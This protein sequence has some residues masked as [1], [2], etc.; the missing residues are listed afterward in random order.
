M[1]EAL[2]GPSNA[3][4]NLQK[5]TSVDRTLQQDRITSSRRLEQ[6][7]R[8]SSQ[9]TGALD[10]EFHAFQAPRIPNIPLQRAQLPLAHITR[11]ATP[12]LK[13][14]P[15]WASDFQK[16]NVSDP[17]TILPQ[18][19]QINYPLDTI[20]GGWHTE[21]MS[22]KNLPSQQMNIPQTMLQP[23]YQG[24]EPYVAGDTYA[25]GPQRMLPEQAIQGN[26][27]YDDAAFAQAFDQA[28]AEVQKNSENKGKEKAP[29]AFDMSFACTDPGDVMG[30]Y[31]FDAAQLGLTQEYTIPMTESEA[32]VLQTAYDEQLG[33][34]EADLPRIGA[35][36]ILAPPTSETLN[37]QVEADELSRTAGYLLDTLKDE[38]NVKFQQSSFLALMRQLRDK[39]VQVDG[40]K[41][42][43]VSPFSLSDNRQIIG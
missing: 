31:E 24:F 25:L 11:Y 16:L 21:S 42:I 26:L 19:Q 43:P 7:F 5:H 4:Q 34:K 13:G 38:K 35:D 41:M 15:D 32:Q 20:Q 22:Q 8:S 14:L 28:T 27:Q 17:R 29:E 6:G 18:A 10:A 3:I 9:T 37:P 36:T 12:P 23:R 39:E 33:T 30:E 2:C 40:D 1:A